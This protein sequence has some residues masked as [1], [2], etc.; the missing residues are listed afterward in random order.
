[1]LWW[2]TH[3]LISLALAL[4]GTECFFFLGSCVL[5]LSR[6]IENADPSQDRRHQQHSDCDPA[7]PVY[8]R[9]TWQVLPCTAGS[10][11]LRYDS[12]LPKCLLS[13]ERSHAPSVTVYHSL[14]K[15][16]AS[17]PCVSSTSVSLSPPSPTHF[18]SLFFFS[19]SPLSL[20]FCR[21]GVP[22]AVQG[23]TAAV[24]LHSGD[25]HFCAGQFALICSLP[26][27]PGPCAAVPGGCL[28]HTAGPI[29]PAHA[30]LTRWE[31]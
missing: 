21:P 19:L 25:Q 1:M 13:S 29:L 4:A 18:L 22:G 15:F 16:S 7:L 27:M 11:F 2:M 12:T 10:A 30:K 6:I 31:A 24:T 17:N 3:Y 23:C 14:P 9:Y 8:T 26:A 28:H 20:P 5:S